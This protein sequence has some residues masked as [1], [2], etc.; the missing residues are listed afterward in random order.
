M[1]LGQSILLDLAFPTSW[2]GQTR[3]IQ[4]IPAKKQGPNDKK[5]KLFLE[6]QNI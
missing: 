5:L 2:P 1:F 6:K 3:A 4:S